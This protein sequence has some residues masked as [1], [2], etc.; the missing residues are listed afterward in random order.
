MGR[1]DWTFVRTGGDV[2]D[3]A[4]FIR[5]NAYDALMLNR[6][7]VYAGFSS[8]GIVP[9]R[10]TAQIG[11]SWF[12]LL[13]ITLL[14]AEIDSAAL[15]D[16][17]SG[18]NLCLGGKALYGGPDFFLGV[19]HDSHLLLSGIEFHEVGVVPV[20]GRADVKPLVFSFYDGEVTA[21]LA[22]RFL[23]DAVCF[24]GKRIFRCL[25]SCPQT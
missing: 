6:N 3:S 5:S 23:G 21:L 18:V 9:H 4:R 10:V 13:R 15:A 19:Y 25:G 24:G 1:F 20:L 17:V 12:P 7:L 22:N 8:G 14:C 16:V 2:C 11:A